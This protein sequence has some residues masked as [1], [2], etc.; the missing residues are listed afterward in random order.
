MPNALDR[1]AVL[2]GAVWCLVIAM[3]AAVVQS[4]LADEDAGT[5]QSNW[6]FL[7]LL[8]IVAAYLLGGAQ[9]GKRALDAPFLNGAAATVAAFGVVQLVGIVVRL[10][11]GDGISV[12]ALVFNALLA[13][14]IG[15]VGAWFGARR[16]AAALQQ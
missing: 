4:V 16:G 5:D 8:A 12:V 15:T 7:A 9:A 14:S 2:T 1:R 10:A 3:P 11:R 6:V 13:A